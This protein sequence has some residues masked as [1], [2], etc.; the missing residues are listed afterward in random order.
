M[1]NRS[2]Q[3][4]IDHNPERSALSK[5][6]RNTIMAHKLMLRY[7]GPACARRYMIERDDHVFWS[8][9]GW[10]EHHSQAILYRLMG[11]AHAACA[12]IQ[13][14]A[15]E[16][17]PRREFRCTLTVAV[18]GDDVA[19]VTLADVV[20]YLSDAMLVSLDYE[21]ADDGLVADAHVECRVR[22][23]QLKEVS[24]RKRRR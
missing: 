23:S 1:S 13:Q 3:T 8:G 18:V 22:L 19:G 6:A 11:D 4:L 7:T 10:V 5:P 12:A 16:G 21:A 9:S 2:D 17:K 14:E 24:A 20:K 15:V